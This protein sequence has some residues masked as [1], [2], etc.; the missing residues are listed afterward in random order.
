MGTLSI[1]VPM[2]PSVKSQYAALPASGRRAS[3]ACCAVVT[4]VTPC[5]CRV[6]AV[7]RMM[8]YIAGESA[9]GHHAE[10]G[11]QELHGDHQREGHD[12][13]PE[14]S[15]AERSPGDRVGR[16]ARRVV[17]GC[18]RGEP[19]A[20]VGEEPGARRAGRTVAA[21]RMPRAP[22]FTPF[23]TCILTDGVRAVAK[24]VSFVGSMSRMVVSC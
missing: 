18:S 11:A 14:R 13:R 12:G 3:A 2:M 16:Y 21:V 9:T 20:E 24:R 23:V 6:A 19:G 10:A 22:F 4:C 1:P 15:V 7:V 5:A 17:V 8:K